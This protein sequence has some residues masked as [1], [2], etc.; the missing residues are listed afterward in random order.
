MAQLPDVLLA[1]HQRGREITDYVS[2]VAAGT[3]LA[4]SEAERFA[5]TLDAFVG[6]YGPHAAR[7]DTE[8]F[9]AWKAALGEKRYDEMGEQFEDLEQR[10]F[11]HDGFD[12]ALER[13]AKIEAAFGMSDL[14]SVTAP[15]PPML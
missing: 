3:A 12:D 13:M 7:E 2:Q 5:A 9:P 10:M 11:G 8:L 14:A 15:P 6:M 4:A 1:Q